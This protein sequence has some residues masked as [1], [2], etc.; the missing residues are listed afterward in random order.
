MEKTLKRIGPLLDRLRPSETAIL[1]G[2]AVAVG[3]GTGLGAV[4]FIDL[5]A[6]VE[7]L[8]FDTA[9]AGWWRPRCSAGWRPAR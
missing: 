5:I 1:I 4:L 8:F 7:S 3:A 6:A 9:T 2:T